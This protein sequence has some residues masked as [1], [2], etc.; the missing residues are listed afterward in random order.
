MGSF[1]EF[2]SDDDGA[3]TIDWVALVS[4]VLLLGIMAVYAIFNGSVPGVVLNINST[5]TSMAVDVDVGVAPN[6]NCPKTK[7]G[8]K[9]KK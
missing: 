9:C 8:I 3:V 2:F 4:G 6:F 5:L 7:K 1:T